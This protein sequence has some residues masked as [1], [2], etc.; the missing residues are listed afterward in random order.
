MLADRRGGR[1]ILGSCQFALGPKPVCQ[2][3]AVALLE[4]DEVRAL[5]DLMVIGSRRLGL[6][7]SRAGPLRGGRGVVGHRDPPYSAGHQRVVRCYGHARR[8]RHGGQES[9]RV[10]KRQPRPHQAIKA[11]AGKREDRLSARSIP[12]FQQQIRD[13]TSGPTAWRRSSS[14]PPAIVPANHVCRSPIQARSTESTEAR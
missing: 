1:R 12:H 2:L 5:R 10:T 8:V 3:V 7:L 11:P 4:V 9:Y 14:L 13:G 6:G